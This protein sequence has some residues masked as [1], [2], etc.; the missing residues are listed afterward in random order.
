M[1]TGSLDRDSGSDDIAL[2]TVGL[3]VSGLTP[4]SSNLEPSKLERVVLVKNIVYLSYLKL[5]E[6]IGD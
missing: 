2:Q 4:D 6:V 3:W 5:F 1:R